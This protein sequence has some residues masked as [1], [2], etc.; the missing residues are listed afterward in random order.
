M[1]PQ[2]HVEICRHIVTTRVARRAHARPAGGP[3]VHLELGVGPPRATIVTACATGS[4]NYNTLKLTTHAPQPNKAT[5]H[6]Q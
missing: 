6:D 4:R 3:Q 5:T 2:G 1:V